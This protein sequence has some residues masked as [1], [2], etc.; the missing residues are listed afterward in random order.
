[1]ATRNE[2]ILENQ[3]LGSFRNI[4]MI[5]FLFKSLIRVFRHELIKGLFRGFDFDRF[6]YIGATP[7]VYQTRAFFGCITDLLLSGDEVDFGMLDS[8][9]LSTCVSH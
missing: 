6:G 9:G 3:R 7:S 1:M 4:N 8:Q 2:F 5:L